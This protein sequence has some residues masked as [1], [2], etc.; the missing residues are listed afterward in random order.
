[1]IEP[2]A[3]PAGVREEIWPIEVGLFLRWILDFPQQ[4]GALG[5][6]SDYEGP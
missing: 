4:I 2:R 1:M 5:K 3:L 6:L